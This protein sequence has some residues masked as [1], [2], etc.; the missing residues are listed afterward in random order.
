MPGVVDLARQ[1]FA[2][3]ERARMAIVVGSDHDFGMARM[4]QLRGGDE[5]PH[6][7]SIFRELSEAC[8]WL[9]VE[10]SVVAKE[11]DFGRSAGT[12]ASD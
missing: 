9:G 2:S 4:L 8:A 10:E 12:D 1:S 6:E 11:L 7:V 3:G 5:L